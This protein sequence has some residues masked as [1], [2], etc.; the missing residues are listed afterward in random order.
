MEHQRIISRKTDVEPTRKELSKGI[1]VVL[2][3][4]PI[5]AHRRHRNPNL[6]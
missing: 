3:K 4:E 1:L 6:R 5:I 2:E